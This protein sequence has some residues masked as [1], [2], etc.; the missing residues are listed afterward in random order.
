MGGSISPGINLRFRS[1]NNFT[2]HLPLVKQKEIDYLNGNSTNTSILSGVLNGICY[3]IDGLISEYSL[4]Y[5]NLTV[6]LSGGDYNYFD[7]RLKNNIFAL[8]NIV[9]IGLNKILAFN[10]KK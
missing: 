3:E 9:L 1:L 2:D 5:D 8:P 7:K 4:I 10:G 6:I